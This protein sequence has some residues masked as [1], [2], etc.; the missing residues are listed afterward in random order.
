MIDCERDKQKIRKY[1]TNVAS[2][3]AQ[4]RGSYSAKEYLH[5]VAGGCGSLFDR[6]ALTDRFDLHE[7]L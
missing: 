3:E 2:Q 6:S 4:R 7:E 5:R 1:G